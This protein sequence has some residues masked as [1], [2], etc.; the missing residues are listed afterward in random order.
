MQSM[1][2]SADD[3]EVIRKWEAAAEHLRSEFDIP[4]QRLHLI[5]SVKVIFIKYAREHRLSEKACIALYY[6]LAF[7][8]ILL[9][10]KNLRAMEMQLPEFHMKDVMPIFVASKRL[11]AEADDCIDLERSI[12]GI[13]DAIEALIAEN[14]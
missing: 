3:D 14:D 6:R 12:S 13:N 7:F 9:T 1:D 8:S 10:V 4:A 11:S 2:D 5:Q